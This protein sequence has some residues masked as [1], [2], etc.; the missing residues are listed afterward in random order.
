MP[1]V[2]KDFQDLTCVTYVA[3]FLNGKGQQPLADLFKIGYETSKG[4][5]FHDKVIHTFLK[6]ECETYDFNV[7]HVDEVEYD[8]YT[9]W[10]FKNLKNTFSSEF[11]INFHADGMIQNPEAWTDDFLNYDYIG[12]PWNLGHQIEFPDGVKRW[13]GGGNGGLSLRSKKLCQTMSEIDTSPHSPMTG[14]HDHEDLLICKTYFDFFAERGIKF[15]PT[16]ISARFSTEHFSPSSQGFAESFGFHEI[17]RLFNG[18]VKD[19]RRNQLKEIL[20]R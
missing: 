5:S 17:E 14:M 19:Y 16:D 4:I 3:F 2:Q 11:M 8:S 10:I 15:A 1:S 13:W 20:S 6:P 7:V 12:A 18:D 9:E